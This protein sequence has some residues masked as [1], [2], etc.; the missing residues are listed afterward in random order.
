MSMGPSSNKA[1][2]SGPE[3]DRSNRSSSPPPGPSRE[4]VVGMFNRIAHR[5]DFLNRLL[6]MRRDVVW[7][8]KMARF[9]PA[10]RDLRVL[11]VATGTGDVLLT[12]VEESDRVKTGVG[13]DPA[14]LMLR[15]GH[16]KI[17]QVG[18]G[19]VLQMVRAD[20]NQLP[21]AD[22]SFDVATVAFGVRNFASLQRGLSEM[23]RVVRPGGR[24]LVLE[25]SLP[26]NRLIRWMYLKYFRH[27]LPRLGAMLSGDSYAYRYLNRTVETFPSGSQFCQYLAA[28]GFKHVHALPL[29]LG[30]ASIYLGEASDSS[31]SAAWR[32]SDRG[33]QLLQTI[34]DSQ[35]A[36]PSPVLLDRLEQI[37]SLR[38][39]DTDSEGMVSVST[40]RQD[41]L[42]WLSGKQ[43]FPKCYWA[44]RERQF[45]LAGLG[46]ADEISG[47]RKNLP[48]LLDAARQ[49][50]R[51]I[52]HFF[53]GVRFD[54][55]RSDKDSSWH[56]LKDYRF[57]KPLLEMSRSSAG[58]RLAYNP[59]QESQSPHQGFVEQLARQLTPEPS[60]E[61]AFP[62]LVTRVDAPDRRGWT[63]NIEKALSRIRSGEMGK[64]VMARS[65]TFEF[66]GPIPVDQL[67]FR[68]RDTAKSCY[69]F[70]IQ[71][72]PQSAF[73]G[74]SPER[75]YLREGKQVSLQAMAGTRPRGENL[76]D[77]ERLAQDL[78]EAGKDNH[79]HAVVAEHIVSLLNRFCDDH[80]ARYH[81][82]DDA[83]VIR[84]LAHVQHLERV[85]RGQLK[86]DITDAEFV[87]A[88]HPT[89]AVGGSP[90]DAALEFIRET[91][92]FDR[93]WYAGPIGLIQDQRVELAVAIRSGLVEGNKITLFSG[94]GIVE[95]S[96]PDKEWDEIESK[97]ATYKQ[98][99]GIQ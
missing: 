32:R 23:A 80:T 64:V 75:L 92:P 34:E 63:Q 73:L 25:F 44:D 72:G 12:L 43:L 69:L 93:G 71:T 20:V 6:S 7:R 11:D 95:G 40:P 74:A 4:G 61:N 2:D 54:S 33:K 15:L 88:L 28:A 52:S 46:A 57:V 45:E 19:D 89:P 70:C 18:L 98:V 76:Q 50:T 86:P 5:Y 53:G 24:I 3:L 35:S 37:E 68:L 77:D 99:L 83:P 17:A 13:I 39:A 41:P 65:S 66:D 79:E 9:L 87:A 67:L 62:K 90:T 81:G 10:D 29:T 21:F 14:E 42:A 78:L 22:N 60:A 96:D 31:E 26:A 55:S 51:F 59:V 49:K 1:A 27:V 16:D 36:D 94:A 82:Y 85:F 56:S 58:T 47:D 8:K 97:L 48:L 84:K 30:I 38:E 91:E